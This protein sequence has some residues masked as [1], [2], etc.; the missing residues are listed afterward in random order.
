MGAQNERLLPRH[1][2]FGSRV[3]TLPCHSACRRAAMAAPQPGDKILVLKQRFLDVILRKDKDLELRHLRLA[4][5][6]YYLAS[7]RVVQGVADVGVAFEVEND[8]CFRSL[9]HRHHLD[10]ASKPYKKTWAHP[11]TGVQR[12]D[13][14]VPYALVRGQQGTARFRPVRDSGQRS[15]RRRVF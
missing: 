6:R 13:P 3:R 5:G 7:G 15:V 2:F 10:T 4:P 8:F 9:L 1:S 11:L 14:S 12:M